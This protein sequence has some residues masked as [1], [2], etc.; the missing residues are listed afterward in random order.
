[1]AAEA[2]QDAGRALVDEIERIA[3][4]QR[5]DRAPGSLEL[6]R[7]IGGEGEHRSMAFDR[8]GFSY[9]GRVKALAEAAREGGSLS[10]WCCLRKKRR[11]AT[12]STATARKTTSRAS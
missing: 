3:K 6:S 10:S 5:R 7:R 4:V 1:M 2:L 9:H 12:A 8:A 11:S